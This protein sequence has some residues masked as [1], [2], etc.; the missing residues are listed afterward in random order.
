MSIFLSAIF[1]IL[2]P[3]LTVVIL[4][5]VWIPVSAISNKFAF[6]LRNYN[7]SEQPEPIGMPTN[8]RRFIIEDPIP[9][10]LD[11]SKIYCAACGTRN[12]AGSAYC[13]NDG[14]YLQ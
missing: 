5:F 13:I 4:L 14:V 8:L 2:T 3:L 12:P 1:L 6:W 9:K 7:R 10:K 11:I